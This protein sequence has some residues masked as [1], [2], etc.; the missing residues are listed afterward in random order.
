MLLLR[1]L[2]LSL[3]LSSLVFFCFTCHSRRLCSKASRHLFLLFSSFLFAKPSRQSLVNN[4]CSNELFKC[5][6]TNSFCVLF[7]IFFIDIQK[8]KNDKPR[9]YVKRVVCYITLRLWI[10]IRLRIQWE[11]C[12]LT[13]HLQEEKNLL[14]LV[15]RKVDS[16]CQGE[17][18]DEY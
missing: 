1:T 18:I 5:T 15:R 6:Y 13:K 2:S 9:E 17:K 12:L 14:E 10:L 3:V 16:T 11:R 4:P 8:R 7:I